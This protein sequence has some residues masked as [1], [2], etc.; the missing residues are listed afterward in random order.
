MPNNSLD[1]FKKRKKLKNS[2]TIL[3]N[4]VDEN[5][6]NKFLNSNCDIDKVNDVYQKT[7]DFYD[8]SV[9]Q[10]EAEQFLIQ[11]KKDFN[12]ARFDQLITDCKKD[13]INSIVTPFG[14]GHLVAA[15]D[16]TGG[17]VT[18][19]HNAN[20]KIYA[21]KED[22]YNRNNYER[23][24]NSNGEQFAGQGKNSVGS[25]YTK[26]QMDTSG[27]VQDAY[28][29]KI[30][31]ADTTSPD[32]IESL[33]Q[34]HK[35]GGFMQS[36]KQKADFATDKDNLALTDRSIN[37]SMRDY[38]KEEWAE[39]ETEKGTKNKDRYDIN[40]EK[41]QEQIEKG[42]TTKENHLPSN[43]EKD[44]YYAKNTAITGATEGTKMA[45]QQALGLVITEFFTAVFDEIIDI[46]KNGYS[47]SFDDDRF[48]S[49]L[50]ERL[51]RISIRIKDK[52]KDVAIA[53]KDGFISGFISN[54][55][56]VVINA[57]VTT[58]KRVVRI[59]REGIFSL[60]KAVKI[61]IFPPENM[62]YEEALHEA[63]KLLATGLIVS[64]GVIVEQYIDTLIK[65][66]AV[67]E[68]FSDI[69]TTVFVG[70]ITGL[71]IT[72][73]IYHID[74]QKNDKD[75]IKMLIAQTDESFDNIEKMLN[76]RLV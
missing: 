30:Q 72:M 48:F 4:E 42:K 35:D 74:K 20:Q 28:T 7:K 32:H 44:A 66:T 12:Q 63:K 22:E 16:K 37:Q 13:V 50:K 1:R 18:T 24:K 57:F 49:V 26:S 5:E 15:Y 27:N 47:T 55:V 39:K 54:L 34:Y 75:A 62:T 41:L 61:L 45:M 56:T 67:L 2:S 11:F 10:K 8:T 19:I 65:S 59:I 64:I 14:I 36:K 60:F 21:N 33:S 70:A 76:P 71:A 68:P 3:N 58:G 17:N 31:K 53:F 6:V 9:S 46:Y 23:T 52:W 51:T 43:L 38:D 29:G 69:L 73:T 25:N 40:E